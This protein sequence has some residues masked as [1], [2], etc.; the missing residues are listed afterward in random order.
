M[1]ATLWENYFAVCKIVMSHWR[2][3]LLLLGLFMLLPVASVMM[4]TFPESL[5]AEIYQL[6]SISFFF[7]FS[8][9]LFF[10]LSGVNLG[11]DLKP[12]LRRAFNLKVLINSFYCWIAPAFAMA[13]LLICQN[14]LVPEIR[15]ILSLSIFLMVEA[16]FCLMMFPRL[17]SPI[18][19]VMWHASGEGRPNLPR[20]TANS[21]IATEAGLFVWSKAK[22]FYGNA[23]LQVGFLFFVHSPFL[24]FLLIRFFLGIEDYS[25]I[26]WGFGRIEIDGRLLLLT[27]TSL[28]A[29]MVTIWFYLINLGV[30]ESPI[31]F[32][33]SWVLMFFFVIFHMSALQHLL[34]SKYPEEAYVR[35]IIEVADKA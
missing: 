2:E 29:P 17:F 30:G 14:W 19:F 22:G 32:L 21:E 31:F 27:I 23:K 28:F 16:A 10:C 5:S 26:Q 25:E 6:A 20:L 15:S 1:V 3:K 8:W 12:L 35:K 18:L 9:Y 24:V 33:L 11:H 4:S 7:Y 34:L 13:V